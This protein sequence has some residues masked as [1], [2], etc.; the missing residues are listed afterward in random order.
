MAEVNEMPR[1]AD[2]KTQLDLYLRTYP[3]R[4]LKAQQIGAVT[5]D[6]YCPL[7]D[8]AILLTQGKHDDPRKPRLT[9]QGLTVLTLQT[10]A[11]ARGF[12]E[13]C[14]FIDDTIKRALTTEK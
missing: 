7:A 14:A 2:A 12:D 10:A 9:E 11:L 1:T 4:V 5:A 8:V 13:V 6:Y 3:V